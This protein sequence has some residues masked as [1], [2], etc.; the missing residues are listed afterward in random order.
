[1]ATFHTLM[2]YAAAGARRPLDIRRH[3]DPILGVDEARILDLVGLLQRGCGT[4]AELALGEWLTFA[5]ARTGLPS[6]VGFAAAM[7]EQGLKI[8]QRPDEAALCHRFGSD[9]MPHR[10]GILSLVH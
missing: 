1:M 10:G 9:E 8:P 7:A 3:Y 2:M 6:A 4:Q 5:A